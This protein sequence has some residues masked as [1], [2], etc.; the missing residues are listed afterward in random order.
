MAYSG[1]RIS[2]CLALHSDDIMTDEY[3]RTAFV[4]KEGTVC[5]R[6]VHVHPEVMKTLIQ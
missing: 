4:L 2:E 1:L 6:K 3:D 5:S